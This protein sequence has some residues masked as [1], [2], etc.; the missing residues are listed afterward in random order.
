MENKKELQVRAHKDLL[1]KKVDELQFS[2]K[3]YA[4]VSN[5]VGEQL[6][7]GITKYGFIVK[8]GFNIQM[9]LHD[10]KVKGPWKIQK[11]NAS[12][13]GINF[14]YKTFFVKENGKDIVD[15]K[16][17]EGLGEHKTGNV[18]YLVHDTNENKV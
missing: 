11:D 7:E 9:L 10:D 4:M 17:V 14:D 6:K 15:K 5:S 2:G 12:S 18:I 3:G 8:N 16:E 1:Y 13:V